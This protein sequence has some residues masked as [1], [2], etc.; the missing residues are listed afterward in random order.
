MHSRALTLLLPLTLG[1]TACLDGGANLHG[2][3]PGTPEGGV[4]V[5]LGHIAVAPDGRYFLSNAN[6]YLVVGDLEARAMRALEGLPKADLIAF[7]PEGSGFFLLS[8]PTSF[9]PD[10]TEEVLSYD[11]A[12][13][14]IVWREA[15]PRFDT[16]LDVAPGERL[17]L[18][19]FSGARVLDARSGDEV[20]DVP[21]DEGLAD[22]DVLSDGRLLITYFSTRDAAR[23]PH[24]RIAM[25]AP[26]GVALCAI[27]VP[28]CSAELVVDDAETRAFLAPT[29][30]GR[31]PVSVVELE[32]EA[33][34]FRENLPGFGPVALSPD[35]A[36]VVA[37]MDRDA[38]DPDAPPLP[39]A[40]RYSDVR[41]HLM[42]IDAAALTFDTLPIGD[43]LPRY[44]FTPDGRTLIVDHSLREAS[45]G[46]ALLDVAARVVRP[47]R[48]PVVDMDHYVLTPD[49]ARAFVVD[50]GLYALVVAEAVVQSVPLSFIPLSI[51]IT[52]AGDTLLLR[53]AHSGS[54]ITY[55]VAGEKESG[56]VPLM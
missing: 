34:R 4:D 44:T 37:F 11:L 25:F 31:D 47:V 17:V 45:E 22:L 33:C 2:Q 24:T 29:R 46:L 51:N 43:V 36:T 20:A 23:D 35:G 28:N 10:A 48:G 49:S 41:Y 12:R 40:V 8:M 3:A 54:V 42:F 56:A 13:G 21:S 16:G 19:G 52:P 7:W 9:E 50:A 18:W 39:A 6:G 1:L 14:E 15:L 5:G 53:D 38:V 27:D 30:C 55:D 26:S 32:A